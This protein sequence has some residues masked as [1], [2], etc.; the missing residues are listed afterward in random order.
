M[1]FLAPGEGDMKAWGGRIGG[2]SLLGMVCGACTVEPPALPWTPPPAAIKLN[3][4]SFLDAQPIYPLDSIA[5]QEEGR[6]V[7]IVLCDVDGTVS[8]A[9]IMES[10]GHERLDQSLLTAARA[11]RWGCAIRDAN[12]DPPD[13]IRR[14]IWGSTKIAYRFQLQMSDGSRPTPNRSPP[15]EAAVQL[16]TVTP[17]AYPAAARAAGE[18]GRVGLRF[19]CQPDGRLSDVTIDHSSSHADLDETALAAA[20]GRKWRC[21]LPPGTREVTAGT[22]SYTFR[23]FPVPSPPAPEPPAPPSPDVTIWDHRPPMPLPSIDSTALPRP[24]VPYSAESVLLKEKGRVHFSAFCDAVGMFT[25]AFILSSSGYKRLDDALLAAVDS[26]RWRCADPR[27]TRAPISTRV[28]ATYLFQ[29]PLVKK[30][31]SP[32]HN[33]SPPVPAPPATPNS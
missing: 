18:Q 15:P 1:N 4:Q 5:A 12:G 31:A 8:D 32:S 25:S 3:A 11:H 16:E 27:S 13:G 23:L 20:R 26:H 28:Q 6:L 19:L 14:A 29:L 30:G 24:P 21:Q 17:P 7:F 33:Q 2:L 10:S 9:V 22:Y